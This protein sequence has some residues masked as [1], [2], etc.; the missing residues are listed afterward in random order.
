MAVK[1]YKSYDIGKQMAYC[2]RCNCNFGKLLHLKTQDSLRCGS[3]RKQ[4]PVE[5]FMK[6]ARHVL[7]RASRHGIRM[8]RSRRSRA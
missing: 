8:G 6:H 3:C 7:K 2:P 1:R 5:M 4:G